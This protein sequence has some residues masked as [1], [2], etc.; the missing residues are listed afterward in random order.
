MYVY[1]YVCIYA[2][3]LFSNPNIWTHYNSPSSGT[4][5]EVLGMVSETISIIIEKLSK[6]LRPMFILEPSGGSRNIKGTKMA[7]MADGSSMLIM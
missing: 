4:V 2:Y 1:M 3:I 5:S 7:I 6:T